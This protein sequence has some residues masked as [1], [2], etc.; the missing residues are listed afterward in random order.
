MTSWLR[1]QAALANGQD[2]PDVD[3]VSPVYQRAAT[4]LVQLQEATLY[5]QFHDPGALAKIINQTC[6]SSDQTID[7]GL[8]LMR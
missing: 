7:L 3:Q 1:G 4:Q 6:D 5:Q 8:A 2:L